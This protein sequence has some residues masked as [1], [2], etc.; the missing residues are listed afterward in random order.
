VC[1]PVH[2]EM[3]C[4]IEIRRTEVFKDWVV[5]LRDHIAQARIVKRVERL[6]QGNPGQSRSVGEGVVE[7]KIDYGPGYRIY[8]VNRGSVLIVLLCGGDKDSQEKDIVRA[9][10][11]AA[12]LELEELI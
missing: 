6:A 3:S 4:M 7:L 12:H 2:Y 8:Y 1:Y 5:N 11:L 9:K 10:N